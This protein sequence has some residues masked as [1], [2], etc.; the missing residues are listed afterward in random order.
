M[1][2]RAT[3]RVTWYAKLT[4]VEKNY[5]QLSLNRYG[6]HLRLPQRVVQMCIQALLTISNDQ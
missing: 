4:V 1:A 3:K 6:K 2:R 5:M